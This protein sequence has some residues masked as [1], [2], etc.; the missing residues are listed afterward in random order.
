M[1]V[2][3]GGGGGAAPALDTRIN[4]ASFFFLSAL[5]HGL[6]MGSRP[7]FGIQR[8][9]ALLMIIQSASNRFTTDSPT[10]GAA[11]TGTPRSRVNLLRPPWG[12]ERFEFAQQVINGVLTR[13]C[14]TKETLEESGLVF[15][16]AAAAAVA[17]AG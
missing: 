17:L 3:G 2:S 12:K 14:H 15:S 4:Q 6:L 9:A 16:A 7:S 11:A 10:A 13:C 1:G 5:F 8:H